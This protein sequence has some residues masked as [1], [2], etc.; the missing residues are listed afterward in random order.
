MQQGYVL[1]KEARVPNI[2]AYNRAA[3]EPLPT[4]WLIHDEFA[5][6]MQLDHY[7]AAV[8][9]AVNRLGVK[10]RAAGIYLIFAAQRPDASVFPMQLRSNLG[11]RL[12]LRVDSAGTSDLSL[13]IKNG[14]AERL[15]GKG[16]LAAIIGGGTTPIY[17]QVPFIE[18]ERLEEAVAAIVRACG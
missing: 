1:F 5:D 15:L 8:E 13:G 11:N 18:T 10:A 3:S 4:I 7:R 14:G 6:W 12:I 16:H 17:A 2:T 9:A